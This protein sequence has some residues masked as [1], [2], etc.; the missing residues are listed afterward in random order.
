V[1]TT[2]GH[3]GDQQVALI[4]GAASGI[5]NAI[6]H[7]FS[8]H[9]YA[10]VAADIA[11]DQLNEAVASLTGPC[12]TVVG[13]VRV[14][15]DVEKMVAL[16]LERFGKLNFVACVPGI[17]IDRPVDELGEDEWDAVI[18]TSLKGTYLVCKAAIP[19]LRTAGGGA[20]VTFG[21]VLGRSSLLGSTA[22]SAAKAGVEALTR[23]MALDHARDNI[24][25]NCVLPGPTDTPLAW[26]GLASDEVSA[27]KQ[28]IESEIPSGRVGS[29]GEIAQVVLFLASDAASFVT[30]VGVPVD[31]GLLAKSALTH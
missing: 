11:A 16:T 12:A 24:R 15:S 28:E 17:E 22:Y 7:T 4:T 5:G 1:S 13:D 8:D 20:V 10:V 21:S 25:V 31:G 2:S 9:G 6:A 19:A 23:T 27:V 3:R 18:D 14:R 30:G 29:P 26:Q